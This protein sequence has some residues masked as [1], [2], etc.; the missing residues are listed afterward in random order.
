MNKQLYELPW[1]KKDNPNGWIEPT[2]FC[3]L[4][5]KGCYRGISEKGHIPKH[6]PLIN[7]LKEIDFFI[8]NRNIQTLSIAGGEPLLYPKLEELIKY[9]TGKNLKTKIY[10]NGI[11]L[12]EKLLRTLKKAGAT[13]FV[14]HIDRFQYNKKSEN[15]TLQL[16]ENF[17]NLFRKVQGVNLGFIMSLSKEELLQLDNL[18]P[19]F[20]KNSD[21]INLVVFTTYKDMLP[22]N[23]TPNKDKLSLETLSK[24]LK[25]RFKIDF[26]AYLGKIIS[27]KK[28]WLFSLGFYSNGKPLGFADANMYKKLQQRYHKKKGKYFITIK[29]KNIPL[30]KM[31]SW[32]FFN[33]GRKILMNYLTIRKKVNYQVILL[34]DAP[35]KIQEGWDLCKGCPDC[36][37]YNDKLVPSCL[38]ER[39]KSGEEI[40]LD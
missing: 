2:T 16:R 18:I 19:F 34:I 36:M 24:E 20:Q 37:Q 1:S 12:D 10:T 3:Q 27:D 5:C 32:L 25:D 38:L 21:I 4:K 9:A 28:S 11:K 17:C 40:F 33:S 23:L 22:N 35:D 30:S 15:D 13:E 29:N 6:E 7:L 26:C 31:W 8:D 39:V 14:I